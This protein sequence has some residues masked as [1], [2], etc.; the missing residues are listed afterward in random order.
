MIILSA[1]ALALLLPA[2]WV[3]GRRAEEDGE[4][5]KGGSWFLHGVWLLVALKLAILLHL[6]MSGYVTQWPDDGVR[7]VMTTYFE[8]EMRL[9]P[10]D[11]IWPGGPF[12]LGGLAMRLADDPVVAIRWLAIGFAALS[13]LSMAW[14]TR[15]ATGSSAAALASAGFITV[16]P[17]HTELSNGTMTEVPMATFMTLAMAAYIRGI[18]LVPEFRRDGWTMLLLSG[19]CATAAS[20]YRYEGW[21]FMAALFAVAWAGFVYQWWRKGRVAAQPLVAPL[22]SMTALALSFPLAWA[23]DSWR[24]HGHPLYFFRAQT[25][26]NTVGVEGSLYQRLMLF[27][28][29]IDL[30]IHHLL[31]LLIAGMAICMIFLV[32]RVDLLRYTA[33]ALIYCGMVMGMVAVKGTGVSMERYSISLIVAL[34]PMIGIPVGEGLRMAVARQYSLGMRVVTASASGIAAICV[35]L[36][37]IR[38][39][40]ETLDY[41]RWGYRTESFLAGALL[42]QEFSHPHLLPGIAHGGR[43]ILWQTRADE[44]LAHLY[45]LPLLSG[46]YPDR[47]MIHIGDWIAQESASEAN[48]TIL[49]FG[50]EGNFQPEDMDLVLSAGTLQVFHRPPRQ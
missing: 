4:A 13:V 16:L 18:R 1:V 5:A 28:R 21:I 27:P 23:I 46:H 22:I 42:Q 26:M 34:A 33:L 41:Q 38:S 50:N 37:G 6:V 36:F 7:F 48:L 44:G 47:I 25:A 49:R 10:G 32:R 45:H 15:E 43:V 40:R 2:V 11:H 19:F 31:G 12:M 35:V 9:G 14:L 20:S 17:M 30:Q 39:F 24:V 29:S 8:Q 3:A